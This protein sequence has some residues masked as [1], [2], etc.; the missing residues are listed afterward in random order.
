M[1]KL[2][3]CLD[4]V[5]AHPLRLPV[6]LTIWMDSQGELVRCHTG[7]RSFALYSCLKLDYCRAV[8]I[9]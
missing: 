9:L 5:S 2:D 4:E 3:Q 6:E 8:F 7:I 1:D